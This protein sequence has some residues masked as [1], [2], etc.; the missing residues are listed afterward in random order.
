MIKEIMTRDYKIDNIKAIAMMLIILAHCEFPLQVNNARSFDVITLVF[1]STLVVNPKYIIN[2]EAFKRK[3]PK[4]IKRLLVPTII[5]SVCMIIFQWGVYTRVGRLD[6][7]SLKTIVNTF[8]LCEDSI[9]YVWVIKI[10]LINFLCMPLIY[11]IV[12][13]WKGLF[14]HIVILLGSCILYVILFLVYKKFLSENYLCWIIFHEWILCG[15][16]YLIVAYEAFYFKNVIQ[17]KKYN[18]FYWSIILAITILVYR[19]FSPALDKRSFGI[20]YLAYSMIVTYLLLKI[21]PN[22]RN[23]ICVWISKNSMAI[24]Y[25]HTFFIFILGN[26]RSVLNIQSIYF[27][28][29]EWFITALGSCVL[30]GLYNRIKSKFMQKKKYTREIYNAKE[31]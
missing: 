23:R 13:R 20:Q 3:L 19:N 4:R 1:M 16:L 27:S 30:V 28:I 15:L 10:F 12:K 8:L 18:I 2:K 22:K 11:Y 25:I 24:Y 5:F 26:G 9:G 17:W 6:L 7:L 21:V 31:R 29:F 14:Y